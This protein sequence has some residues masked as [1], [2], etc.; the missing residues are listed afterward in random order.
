MWKITF[1]GEIIY[2]SFRNCNS[3]NKCLLWWFV[4]VL[5]LFSLFG[6]LFIKRR[7]FHLFLKRLKSIRLQIQMNV[8]AIM[9]DV[10]LMHHVL[11]LLAHSVVNASKDFLVKEELVM[12]CYYCIAHLSLYTIL[13][14]EYMT[15]ILSNPLQLY[16]CIYHF[17]SFLCKIIV[18]W[19]FGELAIMFYIFG[20][21]MA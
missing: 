19:F 20:I 18:T 8:P 12:V 21:H 3:H 9:E 11:I 6:R 1:V 7:V 10:I 17:I 5:Q 15:V 4:F 13:I 2:F 14:F 16:H